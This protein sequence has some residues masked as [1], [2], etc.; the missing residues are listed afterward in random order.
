MKTRM[1]Q[2]EEQI[3]QRT[4]ATL[5]LVFGL[6]LLFKVAFMVFE[7]STVNASTIATILTK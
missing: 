3:A 1:R 7:V 2:T 5:I 6:G 4:K